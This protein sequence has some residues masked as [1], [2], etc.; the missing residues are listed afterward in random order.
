VTD[1]LLLNLQSLSRI[2]ALLNWAEFLL[3]LSLI[4]CVVSLGLMLAT[5]IRWNEGRA[6]QGRAE[7]RERRAWDHEQKA[8]EAEETARMVERHYRA[9]VADG[10]RPCGCEFH[11]DQEH[12]D[13]MLSTRILRAMHET[14]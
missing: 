2:G 5:L 11:A 14:S 4:F 10:R 3:S 9:L 1:P 8:L 12:F 7:D 6:T 13:S